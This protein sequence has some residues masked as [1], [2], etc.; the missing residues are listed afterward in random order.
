MGG[1]LPRWG[2]GVSIAIRRGTRDDYGAFDVPNMMPQ[3]PA[4]HEHYEKLADKIVGLDPDDQNSVARLQYCVSRVLLHWSKVTKLAWK[5]Y[6]LHG[7]EERIFR[8]T[9][10]PTVAPQTFQK[11]ATFEDIDVSVQFDVRL[12]NPEYRDKVTENVIKILQADTEGAGD[13][14]EAMNVL[15]L[16]N[17][18][19]HARRILR[20]GEDARADILRKVSQDLTLIRSGQSTPAQASGAQI[21]LDYIE[22]WAMQEDVMAELQANPLFGQRLELYVNEYTMQLKQQENAANGAR[23]GEPSDLEGVTNA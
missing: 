10:D 22:Q 2:S 8:I 6:K 4:M 18:P 1:N 20:T 14:R 12:N 11:G 3:T 23:G 16:L 7:P 19:Q 15:Y 17:L 21:A 5:M 9:G 13:R